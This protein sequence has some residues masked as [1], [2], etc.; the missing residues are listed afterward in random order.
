MGDQP[1]EIMADAAEEVLAII[2]NDTY[3]DNEK[4]RE[5]AKLLRGIP[6]Q[7]F[8]QLVQFAKR[9]EDFTVQKDKNQT[10]CA[11]FI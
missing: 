10:V 6:T 8:S 1:T 11:E 5:T 7:E 2:K 3:R 9:I 4:H